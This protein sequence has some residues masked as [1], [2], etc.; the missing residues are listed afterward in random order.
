MSWSNY[1]V[2]PLASLKLLVEI[3]L[4]V[5][6]ILIVLVITNKWETFVFLSYLSCSVSHCLFLFKRI[7]SSSCWSYLCEISVLN[8]RPFLFT[9]FS[10]THVWWA[11]ALWSLQRASIRVRLPHLVWGEIYFTQFK[12]QIDAIDSLGVKLME[13]Q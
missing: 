4:F 8:D 10:L 12:N 5:K 2:N 7:F 1:V 6:F 13:K 11:W 9:K 3:Y